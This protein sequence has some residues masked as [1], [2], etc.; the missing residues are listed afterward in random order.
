MSNHPILF[1]LAGKIL[2]F[3]CGK[4]TFDVV[5]QPKGTRVHFGLPTTFSLVWEALKG[6]QT[7]H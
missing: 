6:N 2:W 3:A 7:N 1:W 4:K 5:L